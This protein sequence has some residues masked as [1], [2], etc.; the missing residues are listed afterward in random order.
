VVIAVFLTQL[1]SVYTKMHT[2]RYMYRQTLVIF[3]H[4]FG[5]YN[6][7]H[8]IKVLGFITY[9]QFCNSTVTTFFQGCFIQ[10][11]FQSCPFSGFHQ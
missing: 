10:I 6:P 9:S 5:L 4:S 8:F 7:G 1:I 2:H 11:Y 3:V